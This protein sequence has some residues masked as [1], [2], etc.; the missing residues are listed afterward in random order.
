MTA[1]WTPV[2]VLPNLPLEAAIGCDSIATAHERSLILYRPKCS[3]RLFPPGQSYVIEIH[4]RRAVEQQHPGKRKFAARDFGPHAPGM[5]RG[6]R[7]IDS[8]DRPPPRQA[9]EMST[10]SEAREILSERADFLVELRG[11]EPL[12]SAV[13]LQRSQI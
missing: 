9:T 1:D 3:G 2:F 12:T 5:T 13:R 6:D 10:Y 11:F 7:R 8:T 4:G